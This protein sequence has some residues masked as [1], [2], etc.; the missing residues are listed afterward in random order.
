[1]LEFSSTALQRCFR[2]ITNHM[3]TSELFWFNWPT[4]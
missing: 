4:M 2:I 1:M 3:P